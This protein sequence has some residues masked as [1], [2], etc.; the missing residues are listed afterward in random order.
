M[1]KIAFAY[2]DEPFPAALTQGAIDL[3]KE[4]GMQVTMDEK[5]AKGTKDFNIL[6]QKAKA[7]GA[8]AFYPT[9]YEGDQMTIARQIRETNA[10][11]KAV[12][13]FYAS[14]P[15]FLQQAGKDGHYVFSETLLHEEDQLEGHPRP[16]PRR[17]D[18]AL[19]EALPQRQVRRRFPD[20]AGLRRG[21][22]DEEIIKEAQSLD[23]A[24]LKDAAVKLSGKII[25]L[26]GA[27]QIDETGKQFKNEFAVVQN[28]AERAGG[29]L[30]AA[31]RDREGGVS[32]APYKDRK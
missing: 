1:K 18:R 13:L 21:R 12:L 23:A 29:G 17:D 8:E 27:Y 24:K 30:S 28:A 19:Q 3:A 14:Q 22:D 11:F 31:D 2:L 7:S 5:F 10:D 6:I 25:T 15:Q 32:G 16:R 9:A 4:L 20:G 26:T